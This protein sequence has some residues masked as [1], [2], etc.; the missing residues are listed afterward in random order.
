MGKKPKKTIHMIKQSFMFYWVHNVL[1]KEKEKKRIYWISESMRVENGLGMKVIHCGEPYACFN[2]IFV[3]VWIKD[4]SL[5]EDDP[6]G[7][8]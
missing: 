7:S 6:E 1:H 8:Q 4:G 5:N 2:G 3:D